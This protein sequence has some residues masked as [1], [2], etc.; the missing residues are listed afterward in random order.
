MP[1]TSVKWAKLSRPQSGAR[2]RVGGK[3]EAYVLRGSTESAC[4]KNM[5]IN[6]GGSIYILYIR[7]RF[8]FISTSGIAIESVRGYKR[9]RQ[10]Q[11][12]FSFVPLLFGVV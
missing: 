11:F 7:G 12:H 8:L 4:K 1:R 3:R 10:P 5:R 6:F 2:E 9:H